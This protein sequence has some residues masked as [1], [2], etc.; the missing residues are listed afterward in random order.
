MNRRNVGMVIRES[1]LEG[2]YHEMGHVLAMLHFFP[3]EERV[4]SISFAKKASGG[5]GFDMN[6]HEVSWSLPKQ[7]DA[8]IMCFIGGGIFQQMK[9]KYGELKKHSEFSQCPVD[10]L[11]GYFSKFVKCPIEGME[12]DMAN[13]NRVYGK[14]LQ[15]KK[16]HEPL[17]LEKEKENAI[18]LFMPY[19]ENKKI[20]VLCEHIVDEIISNGGACDTIIGIKEIKAYLAE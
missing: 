1:L 2:C 3:D 20:D 18:D 7:K 14:L 13:L 19:L 4:E 10:V 11:R 9:M 12:A 8:F 16:V 17:N 15:N 6:S 5:F